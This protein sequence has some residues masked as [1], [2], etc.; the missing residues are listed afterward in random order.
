ME[1]TPSA[2]G[3]PGGELRGAPPRLPP[4]AVSV[5]APY[6]GPW[7]LRLP[8]DCAE[9]LPATL[10]PVGDDQPAAKPSQERMLSA[11]SRLRTEPTLEQ[12]SLRGEKRREESP[13]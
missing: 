11:G 5:A 4:P 3:I 9:R 6:L 12:A 10:P 2:S 7:A 13:C 8:T 1:L